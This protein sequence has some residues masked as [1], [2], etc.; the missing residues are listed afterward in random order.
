MSLHSQAE[1]VV[2]AETA[3]VTKAIFPGSDMEVVVSQKLCAV[4]SAYNIN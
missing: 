4:R 1:Y 2:P 3:K